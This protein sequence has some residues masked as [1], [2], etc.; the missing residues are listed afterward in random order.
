MRNRVIYDK[1]V[2]ILTYIFRYDCFRSYN[3]S[4]L[5][6]MSASPMNVTVLDKDEVC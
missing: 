3:K 6:L 2:C 5:M 4:S 1:I